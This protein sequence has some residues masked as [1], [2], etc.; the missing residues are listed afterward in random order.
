MIRSFA[1]IPDG[2]TIMAIGGEDAKTLFITARA[3]LYQTPL[4]VPGLPN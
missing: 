3:A 1:N 2:I 4:N